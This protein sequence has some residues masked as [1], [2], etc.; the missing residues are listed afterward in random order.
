[1]LDAETKNR[2]QKMSNLEIIQEM[3][4]KIAET[5]EF[6]EFCKAQ[7]LKSP[8]FEELAKKHGKELKW[9]FELK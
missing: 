7:L 1:M 9:K 2:L 4:R 6:L 5:D 8:E 3:A